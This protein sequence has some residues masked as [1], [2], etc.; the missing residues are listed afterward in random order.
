MYLIICLHRVK[1]SFFLNLYPDPFP[2]I[3]NKALF[4]FIIFLRG[5]N[6]FGGSIVLT[7]LKFFLVSFPKTKLT[8]KYSFGMPRKEPL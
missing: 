1:K 7:L 4:F 3:K 6:L 2:P 8:E 5:L